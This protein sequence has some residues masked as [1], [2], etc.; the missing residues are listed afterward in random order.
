M[1]Y[2]EPPDLIHPSVCLSIDGWMPMGS[3]GF[4]GIPEAALV[5]EVPIHPSPYRWLVD[6]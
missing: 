6:P 1:R 3:S 2:M 4:A 5:W